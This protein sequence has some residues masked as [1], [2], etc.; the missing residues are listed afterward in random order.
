MLDVTDHVLQLAQFNASHAND[1]KQ[2]LSACCRFRQHAG[3]RL[4]TVFP[5][6]NKTQP[7]VPATGM[8]QPR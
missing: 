6:G 3:F 1:K 5:Q 4:S 8:V 2:P 7:V